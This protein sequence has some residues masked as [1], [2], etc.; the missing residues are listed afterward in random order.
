MITPTVGRIVHVYQRPG[1]LDPDA[2][3]A[4]IVTRVWN[5]RLINVAGW[6]ANGAPFSFTSLPL[7]QPGDTHA[8]NCAHAEWMAYQ[9][10]QAAKTEALEAALKPSA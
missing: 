8:Q 4:A 6:D 1:S 5:D 3:E 7:E 10:G 9:K 2:P